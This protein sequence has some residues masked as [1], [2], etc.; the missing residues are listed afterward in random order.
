MIPE[1]EQ[2]SEVVYVIVVDPPEI[3]V[4]TPVEEIVAIAVLDDTHG[5]VALGVPEP[6]SC[7]VEPPTVIF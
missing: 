1:T 4:T 2:P 5:V 7:K 3:A 6:V